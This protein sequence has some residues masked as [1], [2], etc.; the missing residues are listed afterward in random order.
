MTLSWKVKPTDVERVRNVVARGVKSNTF[1]QNRIRRNVT[2][3]APPFR[4]GDFWEVVVGCLLTTRQR[5]GPG[6]QV[7][8]FLS[9]NPSPLSLDACQ[10]SDVE[11]LAKRAF[12]DFG[13]IRFVPTIAVRLSANLVWLSERGWGLVKSE[14]D[15]LLSQRLANPEPAHA[16]TERRSARFIQKNLQGFGPK[17]S[18]NLWQWLGVTRYEI[19]IDMRVTKWLNDNL[20]ANIESKYLGNTAYYESVEDFIQALSNEAGVVPCVLDAA[21]FASGFRE[22]EADELSR[23]ESNN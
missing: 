11:S 6:S 8:K 10:S 5:S 4:R 9:L 22:W 2:G 12:T 19:P 3:P 7:G 13:G 21:M 1:V 17:Q 20:S 14:Y 15:S 23:V 16:A 18:R